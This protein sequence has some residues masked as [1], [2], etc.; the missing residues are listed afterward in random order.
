MRL[1]P[2]LPES[3]LRWVYYYYCERR[4]SGSAQRI[5]PLQKLSLR[6]RS[7]IFL[8]PLCDERRQGQR[9]GV[10]RESEKRLA[11][12]KGRPGFCKILLHY[13]ANRNFELREIFDRA[14][15]AAIPVSGSGA[16]KAKLALIGKGELSEGVD[17]E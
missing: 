11:Q 13:Y 17:G 14:I 5:S 3:H 7:G 15:E 9:E 10:H 8:W 1:Q 4:L 6:K 12:S 2:D 16:E